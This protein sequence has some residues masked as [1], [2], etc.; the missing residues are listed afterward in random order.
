MLCSSTPAM[1]KPPQQAFSPPISRGYTAQQ[2]R[3]QLYDKPGT[4]VE[5][6]TLEIDSVGLFDGEYRAFK[7]GVCTGSCTCSGLIAARGALLPI[8]AYRRIG[9][10]KATES[11]GGSGDVRDAGPVF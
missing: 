5:M 4:K 6:V 3:N 10:A 7:V 2:T 11:C 9:D 8:R 1:Y